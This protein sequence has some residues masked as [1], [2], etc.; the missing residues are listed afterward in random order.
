MGCAFVVVLTGWSLTNNP[1]PS[2]PGASTSPGQRY[3]LMQMNLC[4]SGIA[5]CYETA[6]YPAVVR[7]ALTR[8]RS[9]RPDAVTFNEA[10]RGDAERIARRSGYHLRFTRVVYLGVPL[11]CSTPGGRGLFG[12][13][14]LT[15]APVARADGGAFDAQSGVEQRRWL[16]VTPQV[17]PDVCTAHLSTRTNATAAATNDAQ[18][19]EVT[20]LL[21]RRAAVGSV[22]FGG[23][24]N[25]RRS[26]APHGVWTR[27]DGASDQ[28]PGLQHVYGS[29][30]GLRGPSAV[31]VP[32]AHSDHAVLLVRAS[33]RAPGPSAHS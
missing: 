32:A 17:G 10:C 33:R 3:A 4:L 28:V 29:G 16:C 6:D 8:I 13:A 22:V 9:A 31:V 7:E 27:T 14:V 5:G 24:M 2:G 20:R 19:A 11:Q 15:R 21:A 26:C 18:C 12:D 30:P 25:R 23:D 1:G